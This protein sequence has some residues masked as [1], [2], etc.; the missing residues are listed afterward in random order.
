MATF[1]EFVNGSVLQFRKT[2]GITQEIQLLTGEGIIPFD[3]LRF[4]RHI[5]D[6]ALVE[7]FDQKLEGCRVLIRHVQLAIFDMFVFAIDREALVEERRVM[8]E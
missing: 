8:T 4:P 6:L 1:P 5:L 3:V 7:P 2:D